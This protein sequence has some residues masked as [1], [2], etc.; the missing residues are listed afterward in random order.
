MPR[1]TTRAYGR[2]TRSAIVEAAITHLAGSD[3]ESMTVR[4]LAA[5][6]GVSPMALY[7]HVSSKDDLLLDVTDRLLADA[8]LPSQ[9]VGWRRCLLELAGA[10]RTLLHDHPE[11]VSVFN[12]GPVT[13]PAA[14]ARMERAVQVLVR[15]GFTPDAAIEGYAAVHT[16]TIG[17]STI[18]AARRANEAPAV[19]DTEGPAAAI[20]RF[21]SPH[22][23]R[24]GLDTLLVG[25]EHRRTRGRPRADATH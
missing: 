12:R 10:L 21:I 19:A 24:V 2:L 18:A 17:F 3:F 15:D 23:Y 1:T 8:G 13:T 20:G 4:K 25:L 22:Q 7:R 9:A 14:V 11:L 5:D 16:Y 6:L